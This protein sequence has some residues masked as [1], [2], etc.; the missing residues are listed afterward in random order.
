MTCIA[1]IR[2]LF[3]HQA[4]ADAELLRAVAAHAE[5]SSDA[6]LI[7]TLQHIVFVQRI[8]AAMLTGA[9]FDP[10]KE[11]APAESQAALERLS[12]DSHRNQL[13]LVNGLTNEA[14]DRPV[15]NPWRADLTG[16]VAEILMQ[17]VLH[18]QNHRGQCLTRLRE[19]TG[20]APTLDFII[21]L[22]LGRP[23]PAQPD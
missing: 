7:G 23:D 8:F 22:K 20:N 13:S 14:L 15:E 3:G 10:Q 17:V 12:T 6:K 21:W 5:A 4:W 19:L 11:S 9:P 18:S 1:L 2:E 16:T